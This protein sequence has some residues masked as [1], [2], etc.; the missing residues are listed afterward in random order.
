MKVIIRKSRMCQSTSMIRP[1]RISTSIWNG[2]RKL[3]VI[4]TFALCGSCAQVG[5]EVSQR[6]LHLTVFAL[7]LAC[8]LDGAMGRG[9]HARP[10]GR[11]VSYG[12]CRTITFI[13]WTSIRTDVRREV[14]VV[15]ILSRDRISRSENPDLSGDSKQYVCY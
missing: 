10:T 12:K 13:V 8:R 4:Y 5:T 6:R 9:K 11:Y 3:I 7:F 14:W 1:A 15:I 2:L